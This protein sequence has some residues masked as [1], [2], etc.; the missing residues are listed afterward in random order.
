MIA[1]TAFMCLA[2][3][4]FHEARSETI[5]GQYAVAM[6]TINR[7]DQDENKICTEVFKHKQFSWANRG[8]TKVRNGW[9]LRPYLNPKNMN[10]EDR[11]AW[12][13]AKRITSTVLGGGVPDFTNGSRFYHTIAVKPIWRHQLTKTIK[14]GAH[15]FYSQPE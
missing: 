1:S 5:M 14:I 7:A 12:W 2:L 4:L 9:K 15:Q 13:I 8:V 3:N 10:A 6:V 11:Y